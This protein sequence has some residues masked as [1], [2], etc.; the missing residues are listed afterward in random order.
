MN[1]LARMICVLFSVG[2]N[3]VIFDL[4]SFDFLKRGVYVLSF[5]LKKELSSYKVILIS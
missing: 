1:S 2:L 5:A 4:K 3:N